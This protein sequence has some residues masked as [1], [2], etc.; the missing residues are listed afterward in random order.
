MSM[1]STIQGLQGLLITPCV[2]LID[3]FSDIW[4][5]RDKLLNSTRP[6]GVLVRFAARL[7]GVSGIDAAVVFPNHQR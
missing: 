7:F 2:P 1:L 3:L 6:S 4:L 5:Y